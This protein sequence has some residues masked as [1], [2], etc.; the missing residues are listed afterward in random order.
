MIN[1]WRTAHLPDPTEV[2]LAR[3]LV[4]R[5]VTAIADERTHQ[6]RAFDAEKIRNLETA[7][8]TNCDIGAA[9][10][11]IMSALHTTKQ[12][13]FDLLRVSAQTSNRKLRDVA[14]DIICS[15]DI[16]VIHEIACTAVWRREHRAALPRQHRRRI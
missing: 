15:A 10:G 5:A 3:L 14:N 1:R 16:A 11:I 8:A 13:A 9:V 2:L 6:L 7:V 12:P 4:D